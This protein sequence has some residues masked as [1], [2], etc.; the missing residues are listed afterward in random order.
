MKT[1]LENFFQDVTLIG[2]ITSA[3]VVLVGMTSSA[4]L[5]FEAATAAGLTP[6]Q[7]SSWLGS[8]C[9]GM[10]IGAIGLSLYFKTPVLLAWSTA[11]AALLITGAQGFTLP[12]ITGAFI[13]SALAIFL[14]GITGFFEKIKKHIPLPIASALFA[15]VLLPFSIKAFLGIKSQ[16]VLVILMF[17]AYILGKKFW[18][19]A[20][21]FGVVAIGFLAAYFQGLLHIHDIR[22]EWTHWYGSMPVFSIP[23]ILS[24]GLP[25]YLVTMASQNLTGIAAMR[26]HGYQTSISPL[27]T[28]IGLINFITAFFGGFAINLAAI[29]AAIGMSPDVHPDPKKRYISGV[30]SGLIYILIGLMAGAF[31]SV[32]AAFPPEMIMA[33]AGFALLATIANNLQI[34]LQTESQKEAAFVTFIATASGLTLF[35]IGSAFWGLILGGIV[36]IALRKKSPSHT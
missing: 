9:L 31:T 13:F 29:T 22:W 25:L 11:G 32:F 1:R 18:P 5:V 23:A 14:S 20:N 27:L 19:R 10:G 15:G 35:G 36:Q 3:I 4:V 24:L 26:A 33:I 2:I 21:M 16:P 28:W 30:I 34:C 12:E 8:L 6:G 7:A 17:A